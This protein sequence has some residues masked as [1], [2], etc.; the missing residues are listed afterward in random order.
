M[1]LDPRIKDA[2]TEAARDLNQKKELTDKLIAWF[3]ALAD[4]NDS[5][6]DRDSVYRRLGLLY[7]STI[8]GADGE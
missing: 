7:D 4:G 5:L 1:T 2:I 6:D 3:E 8:V